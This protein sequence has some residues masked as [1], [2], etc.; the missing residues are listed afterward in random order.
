[1]NLKT[2]LYKLMKFVKFILSEQANPMQFRIYHV[3]LY[4]LFFKI[5]AIQRK[6]IVM[7][8]K[9]YLYD[10]KRQNC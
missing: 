4:Q 1:M 8:V 6:S 10:F 9:L 5:I 2:V 7:F 3:T